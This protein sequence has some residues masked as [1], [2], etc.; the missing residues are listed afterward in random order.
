M[1]LSGVKI[2]PSILS[3]DFSRLGEQVAEAAEGGADYIHV[4]VMDGHFV[5]SLTFGPG[6]VRAIRRW[7]TIPLDVHMMV[8]APERYVDEI[9]DAGADIITVHAEA[10]THLHRVVEQ[11]RERGARAGVAVNPATPA[12]AVDEVLPDLDQVL[13]MTVNPGF[14]GQPF[15]ESM[16]DKIGR[17]RKTLDE[18]GLDAELE[19]D[20][21]IKAGNARLAAAAGAT[22]LVAGSAVYD[23]GAPVADA[24]AAIRAAA[25]GGG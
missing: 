1:A 5:P 10:C 20:G 7:T 13:A 18:R 17:L 4:D 15:I 11:I 14:G 19:V 25:Q 24:I 6:V 9:A 3:A 12:S 2:A 22:V 21:G 8:E 16:V 23:A